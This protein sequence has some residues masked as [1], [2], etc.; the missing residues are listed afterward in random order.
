VVEHARAEG[1][2]TVVAEYLPTPRNL[3]TLEFWRRSGFGEESTASPAE[4]ATRVV[5][6][7]S[8]ARPYPAPDFIAIE[9]A[10]D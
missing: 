6:R 8:A 9:H 4:P 2:A 7:W 5:F 10:A 3:P 1:T